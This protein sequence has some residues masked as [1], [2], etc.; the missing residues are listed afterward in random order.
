MEFKHQHLLW[1]AALIL[2]GTGCIEEIS[3]DSDR[4]ENQLIVDGS[5]HNGPGPYT[6]KLGLTNS[7]Q[8]VPDPLSGAQ[9][10]LIDSED[11][12]VIFIES[13]PGIYQTGD[14]SYTGRP[15]VTYHIEIELPDGRSF[16]SEPETMPLQTASSTVHLEPGYKPEESPF[17][18]TRDVPVVFVSADSEIPESDEPLFLKWSVEG[19]FAYRE[20]QYPGPFAPQAKTCFI[21]ET[22]TPQKVL[23]Y[24]GTQ[25]GSGQINNQLLTDKRVVLHEFYI[26]YYFNVISTSITERRHKYWQQVDEMINQSGTIFDVPP[27]TVTG[28]IKSDDSNELPALGYF[29]A[30]VSDTSR[31]FVTRS[32][33][34][35]YITNPC[36]INNPD[37]D[38]ACDNCLELENSTIE[39]PH[40]FY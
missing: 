35:F 38:S 23:L 17:G 5:I 20:T 27:A 7:E 30:V 24:S 34:S 33:F 2:M 19:L 37:R 39:R 40:Y 10:E 21:N 6:L 25:S 15:G 14:E 18:T 26:R 29:E 36:D 11:N 32:D 31:D 13:E 28:N 3:F 4:S 1:I 8:N 22:I 9:I 12:R 16:Y